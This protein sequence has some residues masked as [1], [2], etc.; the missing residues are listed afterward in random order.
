MIAESVAGVAGVT[1]AD[2]E[3]ELAARL[4]GVVATLRRHT[5]T[6]VRGWAPVDYELNVDL[7]RSALT[8]AAFE[9]H[10]ADGEQMSF[11][12]GVAAAIAACSSTAGVVESGEPVDA[13]EL[14]TLTSREAEVL[15]LLA[16]GLSDREIAAALFLSPRTVGGYVTRILT[17]LGLDSRT[18]AAVYAVRH[19]LA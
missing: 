7:V 8:P 19:G 17:K 14:A 10:W 3:F 15:R 4:F 12:D 6:L 2:G 11:A 18:A 9:R 16:Q 13:V 5:G 1:A